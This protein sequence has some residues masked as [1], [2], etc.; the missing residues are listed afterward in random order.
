MLSYLTLQ[1]FERWSPVPV[2][3][4]ACLSRHLFAIA[5]LAFAKMLDAKQNQCIIIRW[6]RLGT[7]VC[8]GQGGGWG[9]VWEES[10]MTGLH[11]ARAA[12]GPGKKS[13]G[14]SGPARHDLLCHRRFIEG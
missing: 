8:M 6:V 10:Q 4:V 2:I 9:N 7:F 11:Q 5:N 3:P 1:G 13:L 12:V 14:I